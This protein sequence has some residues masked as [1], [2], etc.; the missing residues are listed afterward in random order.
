MTG[1]G[2]DHGMDM[3]RSPLITVIV[4]VYNAELYLHKCI[5]SILHQTYSNLQIVV[6]DDGST[7]KSSEI[8]DYYATADGR[9]EV[10]H[11]MNNGLVAARKLGLCHAVGE[12]IG[13]VDS[14]D[15][16]ESD[17]YEQL[18]NNICSSE[19]DFVHMGYV[20]ENG[21]VSREVAD[22][23]EKIYNLRT[24]EERGQFAKNLIFRPQKDNLLSYSIWSKLYKSELIKSSYSYLENDWQYGED[25]YSL[26]LCIFQSRRI[27]L[28][29]KT[30]YHYVTSEQSMSRL[31]GIKRQV[32][33]VELC[34]NI[35]KVVRKFSEDIYDYMKEDISF[36]VKGRL[37]GIIEHMGETQIDVPR[38][39]I[40]D[41]DILR[42][43]KIAIYGAGKVGRDY[44]AQLSK[45]V[46]IE[47]VAWFDS[48]WKDCMYEYADVQGI[49]EV[50]QYN[51]DVILIA[52][53]EKN[54]ADEIREK[55][56][57]IEQ[58]REKLLWVK[59]CDIIEN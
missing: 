2:D 10:F 54:M 5:E 55:L 56:L 36:F 49:E 57:K 40:K 16:I 13:F 31:T 6:I 19:A 52:V 50:G 27:A 24:M 14:D 51:F 58:P 43:K 30:L 12:Y 22:F 11:T 44:Y 3:E 38:Y 42:H 15:Y 37:L 8:C 41:V 47:I 29:R 20:D 1:M 45:F 35:V 4:P 25:L 26:C 9:V 33:E 23:K 28:V 32:R 17:M 59:P 46:N 53:K 48:N 34:S 39:Y 21:V 7:D 18:L